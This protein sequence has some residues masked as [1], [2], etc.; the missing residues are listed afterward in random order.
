MATRNNFVFDKTKIRIKSLE[1]PNAFCT[2][3]AIL[4]FFYASYMKTKN[5]MSN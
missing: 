4:Y 5:L 2:V 3:L 1:P